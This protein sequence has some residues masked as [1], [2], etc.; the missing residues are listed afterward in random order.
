[1]ELVGMFDSDTFAGQR[2]RLFDVTNSRPTDLV[3]DLET[4]F[5]AYAFSDKN[6]AV[7]FIALDRINT[8]DRGGA[9][10]RHLRAGEGMDR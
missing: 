3:K 6:S 8:S 2:V 7:H 9:E 10:P 1:M 4:V 5:K